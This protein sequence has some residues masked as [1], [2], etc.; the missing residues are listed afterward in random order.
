VFYLPQ[1]A[2]LGLAA[3]LGALRDATGALHG[4][5]K[6]SLLLSPPAHWLVTPQ[7]S[8][9]SSGKQSLI[10]HLEAATTPADNI[11][12]CFSRVIRSGT[13]SGTVGG[14]SRLPLRVSRSNLWRSSGRPWK[15]EREKR[16]PMVSESTDPIFL[17]SGT[18]E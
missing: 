14:S 6:G 15:P 1:V 9:R 8:A 18:F 5:T 16:T 7:A 10:T 4:Q 17:E 11:V 2:H 12:F 13:L 3:G